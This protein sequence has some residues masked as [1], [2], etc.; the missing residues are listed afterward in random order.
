[1]DLCED[2]E[3]EDRQKQRPVY[4]S[5]LSLE[6]DRDQLCLRER[7]GSPTPSYMSIK[8]DQSKGIP[9]AFNN[10][11]IP[12]VKHSLN[13][14]FERDS[15]NASCVSAR[16]DRSRD[17]P[18][19]LSNKPPPADAAEPE[20]NNQSQR[21]LSPTPSCLSIKSDQSKGIPLAFNKEHVR[22]VTKDEL[23]QGLTPNSPTLSCLSLSDQ[24]IEIPLAF[25]IETI[26][27][28]LVKQPLTEKVTD[29]VQDVLKSHRISLKERFQ[30]VMEG[31]AEEGGGIHL[32]TIYT[33]LY[34]TEGE[35]EGI[36]TQHEVWQLETVFAL[37]TFHGR[38]IDCND[39]FEPSVGQDRCLKVL[40]KG[41]A[42]SGKTVCAQKVILDWAEGKANS[43]VK[44][45][46][47]LPFRELNLVAGKQYSLLDLLSLFHPS[48]EK[49]TE[50]M[51]TAWKIAFILDGLDE[52]RLPLDFKCSE[53]VSKVT[54]KSTV[55]KLLTNLIK[56]NLLP[57]ALLWITCR[58]AAA[59]LIPPQYINRVTEVRG[60]TDPQKEEYFKKRFRD[61][62]QAG[63]IISHIKTLRSLQIMCHIP[64]FCWM[65]ATVFEYQ[66]STGNTGGL[67]KTLTEMY[68][69]FLMVQT[70]KKNN[71]YGQAAMGQQG[72]ME[73]NKEVLLKLG[74]LAF[75]HLEKG[76]LM[77]YREDLEECGLEVN[78]A[79]LYA[80]VCTAIFKE[81]RVLFKKTV[82]CFVH[83]SIQEFLA[84]I[85]AHHCYSTQNVNAMRS[86]LRRDTTALAPPELLENK[87]FRRAMPEISHTESKS[88]MS[89]NE[90][91]EGALE[92]ALDSRNGHLDLFVRFLHGLTIESNQCILE[93]LIVQ[94]SRPD[95]IKKQI[96]T[97]KM[98]QRK[99][100]STERCINLSHCLTEMNDHSVDQEI[101]EFLESEN[102]SKKKLSAVQC[103]TLAYKLLMSEKVLEEF[104]LRTFNT[105]DEGRRRL[106]PVVRNCRRAQLSGCGLKTEDVCD[107]VA[108]ALSSNPSHLRELDLSN[109]E[110]QDS[111]VKLLSAGLKSVNCT[112][113]Q[114]RLKQCMLSKESCKELA[115]TLSSSSSTVK[116]LD[117]S[118][119]ELRDSGVELLSALLE[120]SNLLETLR[121]NQC[122]V[123]EKSCESIA[124]ALSSDMSLKELDL[125]N[126]DLG[127]SGATLLAAGLR[128]P[129]C[130]LET[131][132]LSGCLITEVGC[133]SLATA[134]SSNP[135][136]LRE[137]DLTYNHLGDS[138]VELLSAG[139]KD[140]DWRLK[141]L[142]VDHGGKH[143]LISGPTKYLF[144]PTLDPNTA[145]NS[146]SLSEESGQVSGS[147]KW[148]HYPDHPE[149][150]YLQDQVLC[151]EGL[152]ECHYWE[153]DHVGGVF[154]GVAYKEISR[155]GSYESWL[156]YN[157]KSWCVS[158]FGH[159]YI[160]M[161]DW[162]KTNIPVAITS[163]RVGVYL[164]WPRGTLSFYQ[165]SSG[166]LVHLHTFHYR[167]TE[168]LYPGFYVVYESSL[169]L[170]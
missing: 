131:L 93:G 75:E 69:H 22:S 111:G 57:S 64:V 65:I 96:R 118:N 103:S 167:F 85:Y 169:S 11:T 39:I 156:G 129:K 61:N 168:P 140:P 56:G 48:V 3:V 157:D 107:V 124:S 162:R 58:P 68:S 84:A 18:P 90:L 49:L 33:E 101:Q 60:F 149:R 36:N 121:L 30:Y 115:P 135:S 35:C 144:R 139:L 161:H 153:V 114:L 7:P 40:T 146:L 23:C 31:T 54:Q 13:Q 5:C 15:E 6:G 1:M 88:S 97:L 73:T 66:Q 92:R 27:A 44:I 119:N 9:L 62:V 133:V 160:A 70:K 127:S 100:A 20:H 86:F 99:T 67:P 81:E 137:L 37:K 98:V 87:L 76:N 163:P 53:V 50:E 117:M 158:C 17:E 2:N 105:L 79:A 25:N 154:I 113:R 78:E 55:D 147:E 108:S 126:N 32:S 123:T 42:G 10:E 26:P 136:H 83:L 4:Y 159:K 151:Q 45:L 145:H 110:L 41:I 72:L 109:N 102:R 143:R 21:S 28:V 71:K 128:S 116:E 152:T 125:S 141:T 142:R 94:N 165:V 77:F 52:S 155:T 122:G 150:F 164:D 12:A 59:S 19:N 104:D 120:S 34:I 74:R 89:L 29:D 91:L 148:H 132:R 16:T 106:V 8:S 38:P 14:P 80:G 170:C 51:L 166:S 95:A 134:L 63:K 138:G 46:F 47:V 43:A 130:K 24:S 82:Y 112:L